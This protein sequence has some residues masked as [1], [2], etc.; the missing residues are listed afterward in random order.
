MKNSDD[1][2]RWIRVA[3]ADKTKD[4]FQTTLQVSAKDQIGV[5]ANVATC[6]SN[7]KLSV[8][9]MEA[10]SFGD[11]YSVMTITMEITGVDQLNYVINKLRAISGI[12][13]VKR[14]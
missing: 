6:L 14:T 1:L 12:I 5:L 8:H 3:W 9:Q 2:S 7:M 11:G 10:R 13:D 4:S